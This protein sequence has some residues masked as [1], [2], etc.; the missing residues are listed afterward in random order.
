MQRTII[1]AAAAALALASPALAQSETQRAQ[2]AQGENGSG[3]GVQT[4]PNTSTPNRARGASAEATTTAG[5]IRNVAISDMYEVE[6][7]RL[8]GARSSSAAIKRFAEHMMQDHEA[9]TTQLKSAVQAMNGPSPPTSMDTKHTEM[10]S[11]LR[12][13]RGSDFDRLFVTQQ[14]ASHQ[15]AV[16]LFRSY[17]QQGDNAQLRQWASSTLPKLEE[18]LTM[19]RQLQGQRS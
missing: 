7:A 8:A 3:T 12:N 6:S 19:V 17:S 1:L 4:T 15:D 18:H 10:M 11:Q 16:G 2:A 9:T 5:F 13:A 14:I